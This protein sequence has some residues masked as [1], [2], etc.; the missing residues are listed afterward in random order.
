MTP[1][2]CQV[3]VVSAAF[4]T[5]AVNVCVECVWTL[6][7]AG[8]T[9]TSTGAQ[10]SASAVPG[11]LVARVGVTTTSARSTRPASSVMASRSVNESAAGTSMTVTAESGG[12]KLPE[13]HGNDQW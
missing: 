4:A 2:T 7:V 10:P 6:E 13:P 8:D 11:D 12:A 3:T 1:L 9:V 5:V